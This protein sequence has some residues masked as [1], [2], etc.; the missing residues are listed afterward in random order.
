MSRDNTSHLERND[1]IPC[2]PSDADSDPEGFQVVFAKSVQAWL[3]RVKAGRDRIGRAVP[4]ASRAHAEILLKVASAA[5]WW[6]LAREV[7]QAAPSIRTHAQLKAWC[8]A[9]LLAARLPRSDYETAKVLSDGRELRAEEVIRE[10]ECLL[11]K[12][13]PSQAEEAAFGRRLAS[14]AF[15]RRYFPVPLL[16]RPEYGSLVVRTWSYMERLGGDGRRPAMPSRIPDLTAFA[17]ALDKVK[18]WCER[19]QSGFA[20]ESGQTS[21]LRQQAESVTIRAL[22]N[23]LYQVSGHEP[24]QVSDRENNVLQA[25]VRQ[26]VMD[27]STLVRVSGEDNAAKMLRNLRR[28][29]DGMWAE[30][31]H[32]PGRKGRGG[33]RVHVE[34]VP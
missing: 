33:Y 30:A 5:G 34:T 21:P 3:N 4:V 10:A 28:K 20:S 24:R 25:F 6:L 31:I 1:V 2:L 22:G 29:H 18:R 16:G 8:E 7:I 12:R 17:A 19:A 11:R 9:L 14:V 15:D 27:Q 26:P 23:K 13:E 32:L